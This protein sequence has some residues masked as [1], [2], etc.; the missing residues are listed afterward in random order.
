MFY[1]VVKCKFNKD[2]Q[3]NGNYMRYDDEQICVRVGDD[4]VWVSRSCIKEV[5]KYRRPWWAKSN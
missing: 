2:R 3:W 4:A 5:V 1:T